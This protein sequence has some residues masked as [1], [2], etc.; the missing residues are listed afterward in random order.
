MTS[1]QGTPF[2]RPLLGP[3]ELEEFRLELE[4]LRDRVREDL[5]E[6]DARYIRGIVAL[7]RRAEVAGRALLFAPPLWAAGVGLLTLSKVLE[8]ME[9]GHNV[10]HGQYDFMNDPALLG[11]HYEWDW[12]C[13]AAH[14]RHAHNYVHHTF[15]NVVGKDRDVGYGLLRMAE[16]QRWH[17]GYLLQPFYAVGLMLSFELAVAVHDLELNHLLRRDKSLRTFF[18]QAKPMLR[19]LA[20][21]LFKDYVA[22]PLLAGP[23]APFV[24]SGNLTANVA[25]NVWA[26]SVIFCGH[27]PDGVQMYR[28]EELEGESR[29]AWYVRQVLGSANVEGPRWLHVLSGHL[30]HQIEHHL[31][32]DLPAARYPEIAPEVRAICTKYGVPYNTGSFGRQ[33]GEALRR[34]ARF[35][36]PN[37]STPNTVAAVE[38]AVPQPNAPRPRARASARAGAEVVA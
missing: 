11:N 8:V 13:P 17:A 23:F 1:T 14:W 22:F 4:A 26:F 31:F 3:R 19:K 2:Y 15:T 5:G 18:E 7:H 9:I 10:I 27:F 25:R 21:Q 35:T 33:F 34:I 28:P 16:E 24:F 30:S 29:G 36:L 37:R 20:P 32:P 38:P 12:A 6:R